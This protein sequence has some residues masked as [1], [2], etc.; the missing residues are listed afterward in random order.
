MYYYG[1]IYKN[2][3]PHSGLLLISDSEYLSQFTSYPVYGLHSFAIDQTVV[4]GVDYI[5]HNDMG[6]DVLIFATSNHRFN[7][8]DPKDFVSFAVLFNDGAVDLE[9]LSAMVGMCTLIVDRLYEN[10]NIRIP[11]STEQI[12]DHESI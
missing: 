10:G 5:L 2:F 6:L 7:R 8:P 1:R 12:T 9:R 3:E 11:S 4:E